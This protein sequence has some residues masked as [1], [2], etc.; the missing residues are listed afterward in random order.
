MTKKSVNGKMVR[1]SKN[2]VSFM[3]SRVLVRSLLRVT[4]RSFASFVL[5]D[6]IRLW[7]RSHFGFC[8]SNHSTFRSLPRLRGEFFSPFERGLGGV[9]RPL[10]RVTARSFVSFFVSFRRITSDN[11]LETLTSHICHLLPSSTRSRPVFLPMS[12]QS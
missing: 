10:L 12:R 6:T 3:S 5:P 4:A 1:R 11:H 2:Q 8:P 9:F 7:S